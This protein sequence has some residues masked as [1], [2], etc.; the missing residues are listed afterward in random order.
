MSQQDGKTSTSR[1]R[2]RSSCCSLSSLNSLPP[3]VASVARRSTVG[4]HGA[5][6]KTALILTAMTLAMVAVIG[7]VCTVMPLKAP[8]SLLTARRQHQLDDASEFSWLDGRNLED[9]DNNDGNG[10]DNGGD[11]SDYACDG[12]FLA[13]DPNTSDRC[14]YARTCNGGEGLFASFVFCKNAVLS[15]TAWC[16]IL[17]PFLLVWL[18]TLFRMLGS[19]AEDF[20]SPR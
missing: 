16:I 1:S 2:S 19:T 11:W 14:S 17:S 12:I 5:Q 10:S 3:E 20:F 13:T 15:T 7:G 4:K 6:T 18:V 9:N 8:P